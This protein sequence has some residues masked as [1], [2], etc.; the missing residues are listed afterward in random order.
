[1]ADRWFT[2]RRHDGDAAPGLDVSRV[3][4]LGFLI[5]ALLGLATGLGWM[6]CQLIRNQFGG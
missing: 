3:L 4:V 1:M 2:V 5:A 6:G